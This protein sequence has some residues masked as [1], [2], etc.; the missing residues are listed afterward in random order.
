M[1]SFVYFSV[2]A[3]GHVIPSLPLVSELV[4][5]GYECHYYSTDR[6]AGRIRETG[7]SYRPYPAPLHDIQQG[8]QPGAAVFAYYVLRYIEAVVDEVLD[9]LRDQNN[10]FIVHDVVAPWGKLAAKALDV[11]AVGLAGLF[12]HNA[13]TRSWG[14]AVRAPAPEGEGADMGQEIGHVLRSIA[15][16]RKTRQQLSEQWG[17]TPSYIKDYARPYEALN[18]V[19][20]SREFNPRGGSFGRAFTFVGPLF[21]GANRDASPHV[22]PSP[23]LRQVY[24][25]MGTT[26]M[27]RNPRLFRKLFDGLASFEGRVIMTTGGGLERHALAGV[28][29]NF[30]LREFV[31]EDEELSLLRDATL[32]VTHGGFGTVH[33]CLWHG[34]PLIAIPQ[35]VEHART[36]RRI[37]ECGAGIAIDREDL[38]A[39]LLA[40]SVKL[41]CKQPRYRESAIELSRSFRSAGGE[42]LAADRIEKYLAEANGRYVPLSPPRRRPR[43]RVTVVQNQSGNEPLPVA[44]DRHTVVAELEEE[45]RALRRELEA[46]KEQREA[47][48]RP[49][50]VRGSST[51]GQE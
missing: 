16:A 44:V 14:R 35:I 10:A 38:T 18:I 39:D 51:R 12:V 5:R 40:R 9:E 21:P 25:S 27:N 24:V 11:P 19:G 22:S 3:F 7:A 1:A 17:V 13:Q 41:I 29:A 23:T 43:Q 47:P 28:P 26:G 20:T 30:E 46:L 45:V 34:T 36:A 50:L 49:V 4:S 2:P 32:A 33:K 6:F 31:P 8:N 37:E 15:L 48:V 42:V